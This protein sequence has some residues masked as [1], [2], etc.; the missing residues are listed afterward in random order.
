MCVN[1]ITVTAKRYTKTSRRKKEKTYKLT[2]TVRQ[3]YVELENSNIIPQNRKNYTKLQ[4]KE[5]Q[6]FQ[7][8]QLLFFRD[9]K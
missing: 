9:K 8:I 4:K 6:L 1:N 5:K 2:E 7:E 3:T